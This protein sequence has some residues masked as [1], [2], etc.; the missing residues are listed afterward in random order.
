MLS[1]TA[2][3]RG[4]AYGYFR[5][6][7]ELIYGKTGTATNPFGNS[8]AWFGGYTDANLEDK[9]DIAIVVL[10]ENAGEGSEIAAPIFRRIIEI[11]FEGQPRSYYRWETSYNV[12]ITPTERYTRTP[13][14]TE[15]DTPTPAG[16]VTSTPEP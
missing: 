8:H 10:A 1:V 9:P 2:N 4:T 16:E 7:R 3:T 15:T 12:T 5:A 14:P 11:Y 6:T 13:E